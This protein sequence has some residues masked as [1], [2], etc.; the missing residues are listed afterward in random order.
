MDDGREAGHE[1]RSERKL[2]RVL[3]GSQN[4]VKVAAV[5]ELL[6]LYPSLA[7]FR[8]EDV[9]PV[10]AF[11]GVRAQPKTRRETIR[12]AWNRAKN[13]ISHLTLSGGPAIAFGIESG[14]CSMA[15]DCLDTPIRMPLMDFTAVVVY[16]STTAS[17]GLSSFWT[18]PEIVAGLLVTDGAD[19]DRGFRQAGF[20]VKDRLGAEEGAVSIVTGGLVDRREYTRQAIIMALASHPRGRRAP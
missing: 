18:V 12:G 17:V 13:A 16:D 20:T 5:R 14:V 10:D 2:T 19:L 1:E 15:E 11:S 4:P 9:V 8:E 6:H 3:V 7:H